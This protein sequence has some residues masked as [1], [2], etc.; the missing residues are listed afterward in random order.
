MSKVLN[1]RRLNGVPPNTVYGGRPG[2]FGN[3]FLIGPDGTRDE[4]IALHKDWLLN[5]DE[6]KALQIEVRKHRGK[7]WICWCAPAPCHC[8]IYVE[9]ANLE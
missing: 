6:G 5:T 9:I 2:P 1:K 3:R 8:D 4:V 7:D